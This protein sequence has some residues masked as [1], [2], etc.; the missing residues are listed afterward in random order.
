MLLEEYKEKVLVTAK[1]MLELG[2]VVSAWGNVSARPAGQEI[3]IITPSALAYENLSNAD[4][5]VMDFQDRLVDGFRKPSSEYLLHREIYLHR[6]DV[7]AIVHTHSTFATVFAASLRPI[8]VLVE[9]LA[10]LNGGRVNVAEYAL[11]GSLELAVNCVKALGAYNAVLLANHGLVGVAATPENALQVCH[12]AER[13]ACI[14]AY[15]LS[16]GEVKE[17]KENEIKTLRESYLRRME[18]VEKGS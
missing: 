5:A 18:Q 13:A 14:A 10:C 11:A 3:M 7:S 15:A 17:L 1:K 4:M 12:T 2:L 16:L 9:E 6:K 8:P